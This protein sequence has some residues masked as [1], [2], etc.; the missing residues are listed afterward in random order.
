MAETHEL[1]RAARVLINCVK[2]I[3]RS[4]EK[5]DQNGKIKLDRRYLCFMCNLTQ[6]LTRF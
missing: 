4:T 2:C 3:Y 6:V 5:V 1:R